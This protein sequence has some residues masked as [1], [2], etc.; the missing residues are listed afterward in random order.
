MGWVCS[1]D[2]PVEKRLLGKQ[3]TRKDDI[4]VTRIL[5]KSAVRMRDGQKWFRTMS[6]GWHYY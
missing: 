4:T 1:K 3:R 5:G 2:E 6:N